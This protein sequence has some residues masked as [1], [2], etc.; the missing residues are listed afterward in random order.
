MTAVAT[1]P[2]MHP[3]LLKA[4]C[5]GS[6]RELTNLLNGGAADVP[7][8]VVVDIDHPGT[9]RSPPSSLL[10]EGVT[11]DGD[12]ALH[13]VAAYGYLK[14]ARAVYDKAPHLLGARNSG[15]STPLH[16]A[17]RAGHAP[18][19]AL[20]VELARGEEVAGEDGRVTTLVRMQ[21]ELRETALH[22]AV[23]AG[24][25]LTVAEL[26]TADPFLARV[27]D[28]GTSPLFLAVSLRH[29]QI[30][31]ELYQRDKKL[32]YSGPDGQNALHAAVLRSRDM[33][34]LLLSWNKELTK[35]R[36][37]HG[38]TPLH[39]AV[40]LET[41][42]RGM[43]PQ[44]A[45]PVVNG[46]SITSFLNVVGTPMDLTMHILEADAYSAYQP[47]EEGSF[48]IHVAALAGRL[49]S[50]IILLLKCPGCASLRDTHGRTFLHVAVMKKRYDIVRYACQTPMFS[51]IMNKQD[52][53]GN[54]ALHLAVEVGDWWGFTCLFANKEVDLNLPNNKQHTPREISVS[55]TPTG[56]YCLLHSRILI[57]QALISADA[58][59]QICRRDNMKKGPST[60]SD[61]KID[62]V[63]SNS[64]QFLGLGLVLIT[65]MAFGAAFALPGGYRADDHPKGGT[66]TLSTDKVFQGFL[67]ANALAF[68]CSS[69]AVLSLVF[70]GTPT[71]E[72]P[73]RYMH[74]N[75]SIWL[76]FNGV[77]SLGT[78]FVLAIYIMITPIIS[79]TAIMVMVVFSSLEILYMPSLVEKI[80]KFMIVVCGRVGILPVMLRS[81]MP[82]VMLLTIWPLMVIFGWQEYAWR[83]MWH[84]VPVAQKLVT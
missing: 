67:M 81:E 36:D 13:V 82:K 25:M 18:M 1:A 50:V 73:M 70:A 43:L 68:I 72:I 53:E 28:S 27:P 9:V 32:S 78:A 45:V 58:T 47:D 62:A 84:Y 34:K 20:L 51:S 15:G 40:S 29:E 57:Q 63:I 79:G 56:L 37:Q 38:N 21:N 33:T 24:H 46:T 8:E 77:L 42:T 76:S 48:P 75:I 22:E 19:A 69:L 61:V 23:R 59:L 2:T 80:V 7:I 65:T 74:Y 11:P 35:K 31:R 41:G 55:S 6:C 3:E 39:F 16:C 30:V 54:T 83:H 12:T 14:K 17:A 64:T 44:Y 60:Q 71:V 10:L 66:P 4:A 52:N 26:M 49:S 5:H